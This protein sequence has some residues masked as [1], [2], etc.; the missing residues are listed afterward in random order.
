[1]Y[2]TV[3]NIKYTFKSIKILSFQI[4]APEYF[5]NTMQKANSANNKA[6]LRKEDYSLDERCLCNISITFSV[7][8]RTSQI[9]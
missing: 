5:L 9:S 1:M 6:D 3:Y 2:P 4:Q 7:D 8:L